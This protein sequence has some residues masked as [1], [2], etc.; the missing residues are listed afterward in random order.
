M[1]GARGSR[2]ADGG[3]ASEGIG[4]AAGRRQEDL[5]GSLAEERCG[6]GIRRDEHLH[7]GRCD[8]HLK[9]NSLTGINYSFD[10]R[11]NYPPSQV[12]EPLAADDELRL[13][14]CLSSFFVFFVHIAG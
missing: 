2:S 4:A 9:V 10:G 14:L 5:L 3:T 8:A 6:P 13:L 1:D 12:P 7:P 11:C